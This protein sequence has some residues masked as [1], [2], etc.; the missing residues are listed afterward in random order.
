M[1]RKDSAPLPTLDAVDAAPLD[2]PVRVQLCHAALQHLADQSGLDV[3]HVKGPAID[4]ALTD[5][6]RFST[7]ADILIRPSHT[8]ALQRTLERNGWRLVTSFKAGSF[9][10]HAANYHHDSW[11]YVDVHRRF[12]GVTMHPD[13]AFEE[14][15]S[16]R[17]EMVIAQWPCPVPGL[18]DQAMLLTLHA[19]RGENSPRARLDVENAFDRQ[20]EDFQRQ[21]RDRADDLGATL[22]LAAALHELDQHPEDPMT[23]L[24][25]FYAEGG[26]RA[27]EWRA[28]WRA[29]L[30]AQTRARV[31]IGIV[32]VNREFVAMELGHEP[33][34]AEMRAAFYSRI[35][36]AV[37]SLRR[38]PRPRPVH[39]PHSPQ[40][41]G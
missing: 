6:K 22:A 16:R 11:G 41:Q 26:T 36:N 10:E 5:R 9:F 31:L 1:L 24:W 2:L 4:S 8:A 7:D 35:R 34:S 23:D 20:P 14:L 25:R 37:N 30:T 3:L 27:D 19:A 29:A 38:N 12:P 13:E 15:W 32:W 28:R 39:P 18:V 17:Q 33:S 40:D 21:V